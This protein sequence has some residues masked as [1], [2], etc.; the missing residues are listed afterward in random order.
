MADVAAGSIVPEEPAVTF[1]VVD[2]PAI[3]NSGFV[4]GK[5]VEYL[6]TLPTVDDKL[7]GSTSK[8]VLVSLK[9]VASV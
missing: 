3:S 5:A 9:S 6:Q 8:S 1:V 2:D 7:N 4:A